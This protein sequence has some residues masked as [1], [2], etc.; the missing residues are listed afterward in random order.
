MRVRGA[1]GPLAGVALAVSVL[2]S[3]PGTA[4]QVAAAVKA[5]TSVESLPSDLTPSLSSV[6]TE[7]GYW[8]ALSTDYVNNYCNAWN[9]PSLRTNPAACFYGDL[10]SN[11]T[12][13]LYGDSNAANWAPAADVAATR[14]GLRLALVAMPGCAPGFMSYSSSQVAFPQRCETWHAHLAPLARRL[15]PIAVLLVS[16]GFVRRSPQGWPAAVN[17][18][19]EVMSGGNAKAKRIVVGTSPHFQDPVPQ[20]LASYPAA[21]QTCDINYSTSTS[22]H[23]RDLARDAQVAA[24]SHATLLHTDRWLCSKN[25]CSPIVNDMMVYLDRDHFSIVYSKW[26]SGVFGA[27]LKK[28]GL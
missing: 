25:L 24:A 10:S 15:D 23:A 21:V 1:L 19:F 11:R 26:L 12:V 5:S 22:L 28:Y 14:L 8:S 13:I 6:Q 18:A 20:C 17:K 4:A 2:A 16:T 3:S 7:S 9:T 27:A